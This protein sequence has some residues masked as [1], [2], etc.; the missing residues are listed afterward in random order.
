MKT[1]ILTLL[2]A[3]LTSLVLA[4]GVSATPTRAHGGLHY[5]VAWT[6]KDCPV[7]YLCK[8]WYRAV[9][10]FGQAVKLERELAA[11]GYSAWVQINF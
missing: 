3:L 7:G 2:A 9:R 8:R 5:T 6:V 11:E 10:N 1:K 4:A